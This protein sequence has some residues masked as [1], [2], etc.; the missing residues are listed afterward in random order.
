MRWSSIRCLCW[1]GNSAGANKAE[2]PDIFVLTRR[3]PGR[4]GLVAN[5]FQL[6]RFASQTKPMQEGHPERSAGS[7]AGQRS[8]A[9]LRM[10]QRDGLFFEMDRAL[11]L[12]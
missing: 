3:P 2:M 7:L 1:K 12:S 4:E 6:R 9:S 11:S 10:T 5:T 8:F